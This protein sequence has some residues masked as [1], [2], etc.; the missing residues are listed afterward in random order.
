MN[1]SYN[2]CRMSQTI[3]KERKEKYAYDYQKYNNTYKIWKDTSPR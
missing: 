1:E 2:R 3:T